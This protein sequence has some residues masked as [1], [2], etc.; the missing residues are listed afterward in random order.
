MALMILD[1]YVYRIM[2]ENA[3]DIAT[4]LEA[5]GLIRYESPA[6]H[7]VLG[8]TPEELEGHHA[9]EFIHPDDHQRVQSHLTQVVLGI[10]AGTGI[11]FRFRHKEGWWKQLE[12]T[13]TNMLNDPL[14]RGIIVNSRDISPRVSESLHKS[15]VASAKS[16]GAAAG[17]S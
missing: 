11:V 5:D 4:I 17:S 14:V 13:G 15:S 12:A 16:T 7:A 1:D 9:F 10:T 3:F 6:V 2:V 8:Y